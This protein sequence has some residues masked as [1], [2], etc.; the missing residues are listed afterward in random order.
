M[1]LEDVVAF[2]GHIDKLGPALGVRHLGKFHDALINA[3][4]VQ[5]GD[6]V[7]G[8]D[9]D[10]KILEAIGDDKYIC[11]IVFQPI[12]VALKGLGYLLLQDYDQFRNLA[13]IGLKDL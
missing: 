6:A 9:W 8:D 12:S 11:G 7:F 1:I 10:D 3:F 5:R 13:F 4:A 2:S